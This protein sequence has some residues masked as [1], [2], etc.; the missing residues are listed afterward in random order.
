MDSK[1]LYCSAIAM[2]SDSHKWYIR[3]LEDNASVS[4]YM[5]DIHTANAVKPLGARRS[6]QIELIAEVFGVSTEQVEKD[7]EKHLK[8]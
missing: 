2:A 6:G 8:G 7:I 1:K 4:K 3:S 5:R